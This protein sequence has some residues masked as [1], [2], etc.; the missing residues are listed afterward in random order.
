M[1]GTTKGGRSTVLVMAKSKHPKPWKKTIIRVTGYE[2]V[3]SNDI[4][5]SPRVEKSTRM[6]HPKV[7][8]T[9]DPMKLG[10]ECK[11]EAS[12]HTSSEGEHMILDFEQIE[13][14][15]AHEASSSVTSD[16]KIINSPDGMASVQVMDAPP[17]YD[18]QE[19]LQVIDEE[20]ARFDQQEEDKDAKSAALPGGVGALV[21]DSALFLKKKFT[22]TGSS[23]QA[24]MK[25]K[26]SWVVR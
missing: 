12:I 26:M 1:E 7:K 17:S 21:V 13:L 2:D 25:Q 16:L 22:P 10:T 14:G 19:Q 3:E 6:D 18:F 8:E 24:S 23:K 15:V 9:D 20:L 5:A 11:G 4:E